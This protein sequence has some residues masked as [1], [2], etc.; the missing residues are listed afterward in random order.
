MTSQEV[1]V[2]EKL[3]RIGY[4]KGNRVR[5]YGQEFD[6]ISDPVPMQENVIFVDGVELR[7]G[8]TRRI[9][10]PLPIVRMV[11]QDSRAA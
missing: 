3:K 2:R 4:S 9:R 6:L 8:E 1:V 7:S 5:I 11:C 10:I